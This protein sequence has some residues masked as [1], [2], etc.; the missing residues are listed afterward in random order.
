MAEAE[1]E[2]VDDA[3][4]G[5]RQMTQVKSHHVAPSSH[6]INGL[7]EGTSGERAVQCSLFT[8]QRGGRGC[9]GGDF[10]PPSPPLPQR[11]LSHSLLPHSQSVQYNWRA[12]PLLTH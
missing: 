10:L 2:M 4:D 6:R 1:A 11:S 7:T 12:V 8:R 9:G 3:C 5:V